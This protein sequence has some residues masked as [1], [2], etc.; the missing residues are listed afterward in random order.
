MKYLM[1]LK[2]FG[3]ILRGISLNGLSAHHSKHRG[4]YLHL[5]VSDEKILCF[6][7]VLRPSIFVRIYDMIYSGIYINSQQPA[8]RCYLSQKIHLK[9][10]N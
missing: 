3:Y 6:G 5:L 1:F 2:K 10:K 7:T 4:L 8:Y 9:K